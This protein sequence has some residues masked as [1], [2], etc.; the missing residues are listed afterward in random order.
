MEIWHPF[1]QHG[2]EEPIVKIETSYYEF[3]MTPDANTL[4]D[5]C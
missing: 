2:L 5:G 3:L 4:I 1:T